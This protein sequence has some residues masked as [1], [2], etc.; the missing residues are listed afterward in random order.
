M[1]LRFNELTQRIENDGKEVDGDFLDTFYLQL[2]ELHQLEIN[3]KRAA[4][5][6]LVVAR[7]NACNPV[8]EYLNSGLPKLE[9]VD[10]QQIAA[11]CLNTPEPWAQVHLQR[12]LIGLVARAM[13]P[14]CKLDTAL[15]VH[16]PKQGIGKSTMWAI[17]GGQW[18]SDSLGDLRN[19]KDDVLSL[20]SAWIHEW[21]EIDSVVGKRESETLKKFLSAQVDNLRKPY[22]RG[23]ET[24]QRTCGIVGTTNRDDFI[25]DP[26]G[27]RQFPVISVNSVNTDW[28][29]ANRDAIWG[30][31]L[32]AFNANTPWHY[33]NEENIQISADAQNF[34]AEDV[35]LMPSNPGAMTTQTSLRWWLLGLCGTSTEFEWANRNTA[36]RWATDCGFWAGRDPRT[37]PEHFCL[38]DPKPTKP[39]NGSDPL[40]LHCPNH[41]P[42]L[43]THSPN[44]ISPF[45]GQWGSEYRRIF[46]GVFRG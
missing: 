41:S 23:V 13:K 32:A 18:F 3:S 9:E 25:K 8:R 17:L 29:K 19:L 5:A 36:V 30:S 45:L 44:S 34:A 31:A 43:K 2:A 38:M 11:Y 26:T 33:S 16:S 21:G 22:G 42:M 40:P 1:P 27:N 28:V 46:R 6:A 12:Q 14:G 35:V 39:I 37:E 4:D 24:L 20:H 15:V 7:R 10:W